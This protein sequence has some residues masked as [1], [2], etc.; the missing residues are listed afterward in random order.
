MEKEKRVTIKTKLATFV[1]ATTFISLLVITIIA[2]VFMYRMKSRIETSVIA[3]MEN[4]AI[5]LAAEKVDIAQYELSNYTDYLYNVVDYIS[6][7]YANPEKY[8][9]RDVPRRDINAP[10]EY[11]MQRSFATEDITLD[12]VQDEMQLLA[13]LEDILSPMMK[14]YGETIVSVY[15]GTETG[16]MLSYDR[17]ASMAEYSENGEVY[18]NHPERYWYISAKKANKL[19]YSDLSQ[20]FFGRGLTLTCATPFYKGEEFAGVIGI[21]ILVEDLQKEIVDIDIDKQHDGDYGFLVDAKGDIIA[22]PFVN[23]KTDTFENIYDASSK[24]YSIRKQMMGGKVGVSLVDDFYCCYSPINGPKWVL[25]SYIPQSTIMEPVHDFETILSRL[26]SIFVLLFAVI[27]G[28]I[29]IFVSIFSQ[30]LTAP[31]VALERDVRV[32]SEGNLDKRVEVMG[33]DEI[34][35]LAREFNNMTAAL[36]KYMHDFTKLAVEKEKLGAE[37]NVATNIQASMLPSV[38]PAFPDDHRFDVFASM[39]PAKEVGGD[40]YDFFMV[41]DK[42]L[43]I[44]IADVSGKGVPAALY[45][46]IGKALI[47][48]H[49]SIETSL[50]DTFEGTNKA[51]CEANSE[52]LFITAFEGVINLETGHMH[53]VNAGH[54]MPFIYRNGQKFEALKIKPGFVLA[55]MEDMKYTTGDI[56]LQPGDKIFQ[57]TDGVT[58][59]TNSHNELY[60]MERLS[61]ALNANKDKAVNDLLPAIR[62]DIDKFVGE[63]PQFDDITMLGFE[64]R[65]K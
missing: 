59:A 60:G 7:L 33:N 31:I 45:M 52:G 53:Y 8:V 30:K 15:V 18:F 43:A 25:C 49:T 42:N 62:E 28:V 21:D 19:I 56:Y 9:K 51:L 24:Y 12:M 63:A 38:F 65:G 40:F 44:V 10:A 35:D 27:Y 14:K 2:V 57:Y 58:E 13:N 61:D 34:S 36:K 47:K 26:V 48:D 17:N 6:A 54:E 64:Y 32:I 39:S 22:S 41:D 46:A 4:N 3:Q 5:N 29:T 11:L 23:A 55:G 37:L 16:F 1:R 50:A 20:D